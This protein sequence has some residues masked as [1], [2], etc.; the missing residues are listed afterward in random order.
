VRQGTLRSVDAPSGR[1]VHFD[2]DAFH[3]GVRAVADGWR[4]FGRISWDTERV[5]HITDETRAQVQ[6]YMENPFEGW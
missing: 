6:V 4:W 1:L 3:Q 5:T 2:S